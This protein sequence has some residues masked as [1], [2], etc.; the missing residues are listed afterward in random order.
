M[1]NLPRAEVRDLLNR[2]A[3]RDDQASR[4]LYSVYQPQLFAYV[5][6]QVWSDTSAEEI[7]MDTLFIAFSKPAAYNG[8]SEFSTWLC[9]I[10]NNRIRQWRRDMA[11]EPDVEELTHA[12]ADT[13]GDLDWSV[14]TGI[15][16]DEAT[17]AIL[18]CID[19]LPA[20]Q[21][22]A[23]Y[24]TAVAEQGLAEASREMAVAEGTLKS[25]LFHARQRIRDCLARAFGAD[26]LGGKRG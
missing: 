14:L 12:I 11:T 21:R 22:E 2:I 20:G 9:G 15:E 1:H 13:H 17:Q 4:R 19:K 5:R 24:H 18:L 10:A 16:Q 3:D 7:T 26:Y 25:R 8:L 6:Y 23:I